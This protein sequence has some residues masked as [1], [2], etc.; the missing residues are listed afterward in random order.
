M[1]GVAIRVDDDEVLRGLRK[2]RRFLS[3]DGMRD[4][5]DDIGRRLEFTTVERFSSERAPDGTP[6]APSKASRGRGPTGVAG[7]G[8]PDRGQTGNDTGGLKDSITRIVGDD[9]LQLGTAKEYAEYFQFPTRAHTIRPRS[10]QALFWPGAAH[11]VREVRHPG[12]PGWPFLGVSAGDERY[13]LGTINARLE[14]L[15]A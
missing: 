6:W 14:A 2:L 4:V 9:M 7:I 11:P 13:I 15:W 5:L 3:G 12:T 10:A 1:T 8:N